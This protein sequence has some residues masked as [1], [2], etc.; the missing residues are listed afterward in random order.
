LFQ[1]LGRGC[2]P[3]ESAACRRHFVVLRSRLAAAQEEP[4]AMKKQ[5]ELTTQDGVLELAGATPIWI[6]A[7]P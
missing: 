7:Q 1:T 2:W 3:P 5:A 4:T 6:W